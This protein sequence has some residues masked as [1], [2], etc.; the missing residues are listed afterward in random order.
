MVELGIITPAAFALPP[1]IFLTSMMFSRMM[2]SFFLVAVLSCLLVG[3]Q[4]DQ[5]WGHSA[6]PLEFIIPPN[7]EGLV[8]IA[9]QGQP[10]VFDDL[11]ILVADLSEFNKVRDVG[12]TRF[13]RGEEILVERPH[14]ILFLPGANLSPFAAWGV[15]F[16]KINSDSPAGHAATELGCGHDFAIFFVGNGESAKQFFENSSAGEFLLRHSVDK[17]KR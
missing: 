10:M 6:K 17:S 2:N 4:R 12:S 16:S 15:S 9:G 13:V 7:F 11:V 3:C 14:S 5:Q 8:L 1:L